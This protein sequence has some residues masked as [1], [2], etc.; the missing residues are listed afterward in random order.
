MRVRARK[1]TIV[2]DVLVI[3]MYN[4]AIRNKIIEGG[5]DTRDSAEVRNHAGAK[6]VNT[7]LISDSEGGIVIHCKPK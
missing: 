6:Q 7:Q 3:N 2:R 4:S 1:I 5:N